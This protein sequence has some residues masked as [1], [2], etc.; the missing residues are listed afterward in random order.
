MFTIFV[1][2][3]QFPCFP[4]CHDLY[5]YSEMFKIVILIKIRHSLQGPEVSS[6]H[7]SCIYLIGG[8]EN[9]FLRLRFLDE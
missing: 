1:I 6:V 5:N 8:E 4:L 3:T 2:I 7:H 9:L